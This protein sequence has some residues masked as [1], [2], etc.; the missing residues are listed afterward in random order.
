MK[1]FLLIAAAAAFLGAAINAE[2][3][4]AQSAPYCSE[5][6]NPLVGACQHENQIFMNAATQCHQRPGTNPKCQGWAANGFRH[7]RYD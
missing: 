2:P 7:Y 1:N 5:M 4:K 3:A 6:V